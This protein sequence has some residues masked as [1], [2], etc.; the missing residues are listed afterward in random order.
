MQTH[1]C[2]VKPNASTLIFKFKF[3]CVSFYKPY[4]NLGPEYLT[5]IPYHNVQGN[6]KLIQQHQEFKLWFSWRHERETCTEW[7]MIFSN[8]AHV[9][10]VCSFRDTECVPS[11]QLISHI[12]VCPR[13]ICFVVPSLW[14]FN[15]CADWNKRRK[16]DNSRSPVTGIRWK[17]C[18]VTLI[19]IGFSVCFPDQCSSRSLITRPVGRR[20]L[21]TQTSLATEEG[22]LSRI[23]KAYFALLC[24]TCLVLHF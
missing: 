13:T 11:L 6:N 22:N 21:N 1:V 4:E 23:R 3:N 5:S 14:I 19:S 15:A 2:N 24:N 16:A 9:F 18:H 12:T 7:Q 20:A 17:S 8:C 10:Y